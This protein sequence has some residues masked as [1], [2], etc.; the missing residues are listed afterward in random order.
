MLLTKEVEIGLNGWTIKHYENLGYI[1]TR[2]K[3]KLGR[4]LVPKDTK[5]VVKVEDLTD[6]SHA[7]VDVQCDNCDEV[8]KGIAWKVYKKSIKDNGKYYC[9]KCVMKLYGNENYRKSRLKNG[10]SFE[11]WCLENN[12]QDVLD[13]WDYELNYC[14][15]SDIGYTS[16]GRDKKGFWFL[17]SKKIHPSELRSLTG[18]LKDELECRAC[19]SIAY[20]LI[21]KHG[22]NA[23][24]LYWDYVLNINKNGNQLDPWKIPRSSKTK[25]WLKCQEKEYHESYNSACGSIYHYGSGCSYCTPKSGKVHHLDS[26]GAL[27]PEVLALWSNK[28]KKTPYEYTHMSM[29]KVWWKCPDDKHEDYLRTIGESNICNFRCP[30]CSRERKE[31]LLQEHVRLYLNDLNYNVLHEGRCTIVPKNPKTSYLLPFDNE[32]ILSNGRHL[33][34]EVM[35]RQHYEITKYNLW[36]AIKNNTT[37]EYELHYQKLKDRYKRIFAKQQGYFYLEI[38]YWMDDKEETYKKVIDNMI[39]SSITQQLVI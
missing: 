28:N 16:L 25:I 36:T 2:V 14:N 10:K 4:L 37:P 8:K 15:P 30:N 26:L 29:Q 6:G 34:I 3:D 13:R 18:I 19:N 12:R 5:L 24:E 7:L 20:F 32:I 11:K 22:E 33:I 39:S 35:G 17:C 31:S 21:N 1:I 38:P 27:Y 23:L 9:K